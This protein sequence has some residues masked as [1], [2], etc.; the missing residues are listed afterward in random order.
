METKALTLRQYPQLASSNMSKASVNTMVQEAVQK[1]MNSMLPKLIKTISESITASVAEQF[2]QLEQKLDDIDSS[3]STIVKKQKMIEKEVNN[4]K[5]QL[6]SQGKTAVEQ[7]KRL[8]KV[9]KLLKINDEHVKSVEQELNLKFSSSVESSMREMEMREAIK[10]NVMF[11]NVK[12]SCAENEKQIKED[13]EVLANIQ[14]A[15]Q[16]SVALTN[17][18]RIGKR[19]AG[20][21]RPLRASVA[22]TKD[23]GEILKSAKKLRYSDALNNVFINRDM[24][25][26]E[27][28]QW[29]ELMK[30]KRDKQE[31]SLR[32][33]ENVK[34]IISKGKVVKG[35]IENQ[36]SGE[37]AMETEH[38]S[39]T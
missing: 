14:D 7:E 10:M 39:R 4:V 33:G 26:L 23:L 21:T 30:E 17:I 28:S 13:T 38:S 37:S 8:D 29:R 22:N 25:Q 24:T 32:N 20:K 11:F 27:R 35:R 19:E 6:D 2:S 16:T 3:M 1:S 18:R 31:V 36:N 9:E 34:W 12:E 5:L 15:I